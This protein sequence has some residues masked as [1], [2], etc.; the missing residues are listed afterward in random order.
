MGPQN[1][2]LLLTFIKKLSKYS[3][4]EISGYRYYLPLN[5]EILVNSE[6][7]SVFGPVNGVWYKK[8]IELYKIIFEFY[9]I[10]SKN[11]LPK[12]YPIFMLETIKNDE[13]LRFVDYNGTTH[14]GYRTRDF[15]DRMNAILRPYSIDY[16]GSGLTVIKHNMGEII[17]KIVKNVPS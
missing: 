10:N 2:E 11:I 7:I 13:D 5:V 9:Y 17:T 14:A 1:R 15:L 8:Y 6:L 4:L 3:E 16:Y 12:P